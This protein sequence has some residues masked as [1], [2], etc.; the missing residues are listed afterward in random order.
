MAIAAYEYIVEEKGRNST[1]YLEAKREA[2]RCRRNKLTEGFAYTREEL[3][4]LQQQYESFLS[5]FG[6]SR[7]TA[8]IICR[9]GRIGSAVYQ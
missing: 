5:E 3:L 2:L 9:A 6:R 8:G 7:I 4:I 1:F